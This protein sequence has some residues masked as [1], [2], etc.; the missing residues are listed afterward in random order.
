MSVAK[1]SH[2]LQLF[3]NEKIQ[4]WSMWQKFYQRMQF[5][6]SLQFGNMYTNS[7]WITQNTGLKLKITAEIYLMNLIVNTVANISP[8]HSICGKSFTKSKLWSTKAL[9]LWFLWKIIHS[10]RKSKYLNKYIMGIH[11]GQRNYKS[12]NLIIQIKDK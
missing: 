12:A 4:L 9:W 6:Q 10:I 3:M 1:I 8:K 5:H 2:T 7:S 11:V